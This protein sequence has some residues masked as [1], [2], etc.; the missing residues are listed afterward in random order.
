[1]WGALIED[2]D[3]CFLVEQQGL[4]SLEEAD[5][6]L[7]RSAGVECCLACW[8]GGS[9]LIPHSIKQTSA[10]PNCSDENLNFLISNLKKKWFFS[11]I[12]LAQGSSG[13]PL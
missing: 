13:T 12:I 5:N 7:P 4:V 11:E 1:M 6:W 2:A 10:L 9:G 3:S 8:E